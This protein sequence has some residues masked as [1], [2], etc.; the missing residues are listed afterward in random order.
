MAGLVLY[1]AVS[2]RLFLWGS[3]EHRDTA[4]LRN[5]EGWAEE[6]YP[7]TSQ[8]PGASV[9]SCPPPANCFRSPA[10]PLPPIIHF[11][12]VGSSQLN[13]SLF[14]EQTCP[15]PAP[16][17]GTRPIF[18]TH[19]GRERAPKRVPPTPTRGNVNSCRGRLTNASAYSL[20][21]R[22]QHTPLYK[23]R[24]L[25]PRRQKRSRRQKSNPR[26]SCHC[27]SVESAEAQAFI[28]SN[29]G[30]ACSH[31]DTGYRSLGV[32]EDEEEQ[33]NA[34]P[35]LTSETVTGGE[36][37]VTLSEPEPGEAAAAGYVD[38]VGPN[39]LD[40]NREG[41]GGGLE[42]PQQQEELA[43]PA[44]EGPQ[45]VPRNLRRS[46][47]AF[48]ILQRRELER[49]FQRT[50][51]P[52]VFEREV[53]A[54]RLNLPE[55]IVQ[56]WFQNRRAKW[57]RQQRALMFRNLIP[58]ALHPHMGITFNGPYQAVPV[59]RPAWRCVPAVP[60]APP[61]LPGPPLL[62]PRPP[63][64]PPEPPP[65]PPGPPPLPPGPPPLPPG[66]PPLPPGP[67]PL[68]PGPPPLP[69]GPPPLPPGPPPLP[70]GPPPLPP[71]P[72]GMPLPPLPPVPPFAVAPVGIA[73]GPVINGHFTGPIF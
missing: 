47:T 23:A 59:I 6:Y 68:P 54:R 48:T 36:K 42:P 32:D 2:L 5:I 62:P 49:A 73:W 26:G 30:M 55:A 38:V 27:P 66:P 17:T 46:R 70:P 10:Q 9:K 7:N 31:R 63:P 52:D 15:L 29:Q 58:I 22:K 56:V 1:P 40:E 71:G 41:G 35:T 12:Q 64:L 43:P 37:E 34:E 51:Y 57:R 72:P 4:G 60:L 19:P 69:P 14:A 33:H 39:F 16:L 44:A 20:N 50:R 3:K 18:F 61:V 53:I 28:D 65:L 21:P 24:K 45:I 25:Q 11:V 67:P 13:E 8:A